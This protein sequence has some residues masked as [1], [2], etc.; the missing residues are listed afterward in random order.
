MKKCFFALTFTIL[1][2]I[3]SSCNS[4]PYSGKYVYIRNTGLYLCLS[5]DYTFS[6]IETMGKFADISYGKYIVDNNNIQLKFNK[7]NVFNSSNEPISGE[8]RGSRIVFKNVEG[9][10]FK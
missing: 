8:V 6:L 10:F 9:Y 2:F 4:N 7:A 5:N 1:L 3:L